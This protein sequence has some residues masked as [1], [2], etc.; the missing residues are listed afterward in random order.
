M[1]WTV[2]IET[3][4]QNRPTGTTCDWKFPTQP[5]HLPAR[6]RMT[7]SSKG[8]SE[9]W[10]ILLA[11]STSVK[12]CLSAAWQMFVTGSLGWRKQI[13]WINSD[14]SSAPLITCSLR[15]QTTHRAASWASVCVQLG[16]LL[17][18]HLRLQNLFNGHLFIHCAG[19][20]HFTF[21]LLVSLSLLLDSWRTKREW[22][23]V[24]C[25]SICGLLQDNLAHFWFE[26]WF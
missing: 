16:L 24:S 6:S 11:H 12:S 17:Y 25:S 18:S 13:Y 19:R 22:L 21:S 2:V 3:I 14:L 9:K 26:F 1:F 20:L 23:S 4:C 7:W 15:E 5:E 8:S 10:G